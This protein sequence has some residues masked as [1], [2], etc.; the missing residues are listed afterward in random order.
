MVMFDNRGRL[1][2]LHIVPEEDAAAADEP[3]TVD[4]TPER[5][6]RSSGVTP[7]AP[8]GR[9]VLPHSSRL[10]GSGPISRACH[11]ASKPQVI[12]ATR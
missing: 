7:V 8:G 1:I 12:S 9:R 11:S 3:R 4:W 10:T 6:V 5:L 2:E